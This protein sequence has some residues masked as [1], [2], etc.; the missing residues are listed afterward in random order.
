MSKAEN[1]VSPVQRQVRT[2]VVNTHNQAS[3]AAAHDPTPL[4]IHSPSPAADR[5]TKSLVRF[6]WGSYVQATRVEI[7]C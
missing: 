7:R 2:P 4:C 5:I 3:V 1:S 6:D